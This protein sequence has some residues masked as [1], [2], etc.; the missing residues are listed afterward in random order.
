[1]AI[2]VNYSSRTRIDRFR[3]KSARNFANRREKLRKE[4]LGVMKFCKR[5]GS[6]FAVSVL[7]VLGGITAAEGQEVDCAGTIRAW[8]VDRSLRDYM[9]THTCTCPSRNRQPVCISNQRDRDAPSPPAN[10]GS[11]G[12]DNS[13]AVEAAR[14]EAERKKR[15][16]EFLRRKAELL[17]GLKTGTG[18]T[19]SGGLKPGTGNANNLGLKPGTGN[20][21]DP[22][23]KPGTPKQCPAGTTLSGGSCVPDLP[24]EASAFLYALQT[25]RFEPMNSGGKVV[26]T[27]RQPTDGHGLVGG[28]TWTYGFKWPQMKCDEACKGDMDKRLYAQLLAYCAQQDDAKKCVADGLPFTPELYDMV[29]SMGSYNTALYD[30]ATRVVFDGATY[31]EYS[32]QHKEI[33]AALKG[34]KFDV[35][36]CHSNGAM[37]CLA[38]LRSGDTTAREVRL[39]GPQINP[40]AARIWRD[41]SRQTGTKVTVY[42]NSG[43]PVA[44]VS[45]LLPTPPAGTDWNLPNVWLLKTL[46]GPGK[47][48]AAAFNS[49]LDI[50]VVRSK[51]K[52]IPSLDC[53]S[54]KLYEKQLPDRLPALPGIRRNM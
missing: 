48:A 44:P 4:A 3:S 53:H 20:T 32:R 47:F 40:E 2:A 29:I 22:G 33:F 30:L 49:F 38:A 37:L 46:A 43:D 7:F 13:A 50:K 8:Q 52:N 12:A 5:R 51:C 21:N 10:P 45:W 34:R 25:S 39:F 14:A 17:S 6:A 15:E 11:G 28:T 16:E 42:I 26:D 1:M 54:M 19:T 36:D 18:N 31:G 24:P 23:L 9:A 41:Y 27:S 35:L